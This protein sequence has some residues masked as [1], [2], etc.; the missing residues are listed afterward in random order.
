MISVDSAKKLDILHNNIRSELFTTVHAADNAQIGCMSSM[1]SIQRNEIA[2][3]EIGKNFNKIRHN[4][5]HYHDYIEIFC[6]HSFSEK[7]NITIN[8]RDFDLK[9]GQMTIVPMLLPHCLNSV[10]T[11]SSGRRL[12]F[13]L[14]A[15]KK[16]VGD[17]ALALFF[18]WAY[19]RPWVHGS[20]LTHLTLKIPEESQLYFNRL[21]NELFDASNRAASEHL[22]RSSKL[23]DEY[24][25]AVAE[26]LHK[27]SAEFALIFYDSCTE[28]ERKAF[29][30]YRAPMLAVLNYIDAHLTERIKLSDLCKISGFG[31]TRF[32]TVFHEIMKLS[33]TEYINFTRIRKARFLVVN[34]DIRFSEIGRMCGFNSLDYF[35]RVFKSHT[36]CPPKVYRNE[37]LLEWQE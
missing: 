16:H 23:I 21:M 13:T 19:L 30:K 31:M 36:G 8:D 32:S 10:C 26:I 22:K 34:T 17:E 12:N 25:A 11:G 29:E 27:L 14:E 35:G 24:N 37:Y 33:P 3:Y 18:D 2:C 1:L 5:L 6:L 9:G 28:H 4:P 15:L 20:D 7:V